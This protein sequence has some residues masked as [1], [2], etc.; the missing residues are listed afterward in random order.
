MEANANHHDI[1]QSV[2]LARTQ[3]L[4][5]QLMSTPGFRG[6]GLGCGPTTR[7]EPAIGLLG[8]PQRGAAWNQTLLRGPANSAA[9]FMAGTQLSELDLTPLGAPGCYAYIPSAPLLIAVPTDAN[10]EV[11]FPLQWAASAPAG[12]SFL[13]Q[14]VALDLR[15]NSLGLIF[16]NVGQISPQ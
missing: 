4:R 7:D 15:A 5:T 10:G 12:L 6:L 13:A 14:W 8:T 1:P 16:S 3:F 11:M 9:I 2:Y